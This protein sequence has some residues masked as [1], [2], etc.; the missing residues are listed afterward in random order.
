MAKIV[1]PNCGTEIQ[2]DESQYESIARQIRDVEFESEVNARCSHF[3]VEKLDAI[4]KARLQVEKES[5]QL[6]HDKENQINDLKL[7]LE[8]HNSATEKAVN[9]AVQ[10]KEATIIKLNERLATFDK[11]KKIAINEAI[12]KKDVEL[13]EAKETIVKLNGELSIAKVK[14]EL[15]MKNQETRFNDQTQLLEDEIE[16]LKD[17]KVSLSTKAIG[18]SLEVYCHNEFNKIRATAFPNA[19]FEKDNE[20]SKESSS[21]GDFIFRDFVD[22]V[23]VVS[24]MFDMKNEA[25]T[26]ATKK[27]NESFLKELDK[28]RREKQ[29]EYAV[30]VSML[31]QDNEL[32][33]SGIVDVSYRY[34]KMYVIRPQ[35]FI[36]IISFLRNAAL[37]ALE[38]RRELALVKAQNIDIENFE[39]NLGSF[40]SAFDRNYRLASDK[41]KDAIKQIDDTIKKLEKVK[42]NLLGSENN[43]RLA[44][45]KAEDLTIKKLVKGN[46]TMQ[47]LFASSEQ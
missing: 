22:G 15:E 14:H 1:C 40:K 32:Y 3:E 13:N 9:L 34:E 26:T 39:K 8:K 31:E 38:Y 18:E 17:F 23:E 6:I 12:E 44:N 4:E 24:I 27:T 33:N 36:P 16:R 29:C 42:E 5:Q 41:F 43:L 30:L 47:A 21:K 37:N 45:E 11:E 19:Y 28:D 25:D 35:F 10:E 20:I 2:L 46:P 7:Q